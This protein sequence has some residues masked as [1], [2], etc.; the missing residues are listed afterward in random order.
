VNMAETTIGTEPESASQRLLKAYRQ[1]DDVMRRVL[2]HG[3]EMSQ[4]HVAGELRTAVP[5]IQLVQRELEALT[6]QGA[7][8]GL[9]PDTSRPL[10]SYGLFQSGELAFSQI[11]D[12]TRPHA[13]RGWVSGSLKVR[14]GLPLLQ[15]AANAA[16]IRGSL[17]SFTDPSA[18]EIVGSFEPRTQY[19]WDTVEVTTD[20]GSAPVR[21]NVLL[22]KKMDKGALHYE[23]T[24]WTG[25]R[26]PVLTR[27]LN[28][29]GAVCTECAVD[30]F[31]SSPPDAFDW[32]R[33]FKLEMAY[34]LLWTCIERF[35]A[36]AY[37]PTVEPCARLK[38][39]SERSHYLANRIAEHVNR[40]DA[41]VFDSRDPAH[42]GTLRRDDPKECLDYYYYVRS[43]LS[44]RGKGAFNDGEI[45]RC[46]LV[47]LHLVARDV[48]RDEGIE[49]DGNRPKRN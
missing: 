26:D 33:F 17:L 38:L 28:V 7:G 29:V 21:A 3:T 27:G 35:T 49:V 23:D 18:Y 16:C 46:S 19:K 45:I 4:R 43:N 24:Q 48:F 15:T 2:E 31:A 9:P 47:E 42:H 32:E 13:P 36:L 30:H 25:K 11:R 5:V 34:L 37:G 40:W 39:W 44:H 12:L 8:V 1:L 22:G 6:G 10:F 14:D 41:K 20:D